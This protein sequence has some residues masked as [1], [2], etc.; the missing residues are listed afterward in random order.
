MSKPVVSY[1]AGVTAPPGK[2]MG[3]AGAIVSGGKG[4]AAAK[5]DALRAAG[6]QVGNNPTEAGQLMVEVVKGLT[7]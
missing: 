3:H 5:M 7:A 4:T 2:K 6:A 1:V